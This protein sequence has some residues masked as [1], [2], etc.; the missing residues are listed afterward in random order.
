[1]GRP[2]SRTGVVSATNEPDK[3]I[4]NAAIPIGALPPGDFIVRAI[5][6]LEDQPAGRVYRI[7]RKGALR[8]MGSGP[9][10]VLGPWSCVRSPG[11]AF[12]PLVLRP[13][14]WP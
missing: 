9:S 13:V 14:R 8:G 2:C 6:G 11:P 10:S 12:G 1:M 3:F 7:F 4:V 5:V